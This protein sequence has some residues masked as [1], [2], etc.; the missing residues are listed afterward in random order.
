[1]IQRSHPRIPLLSSLAIGVVCAGFALGAA[2]QGSAT[3]SPPSSGTSAGSTASGK[4][5]ARTDSLAAADRRFLMNAAEGGMAEVALGQLAKERAT[6][7]AVKRFGERMVKDHT[8]ANEELTSLAQSK[9]VQLPQKLDGKHQRGIDRMSKM[10]GAEFDRAW[11]KDMVSD[12]KKDVSDFDKA[13]RDAK[14][15]DVKAFAAKT[16]P[17]LK[18]HLQVVNGLEGQVNASRGRPSTASNAPGTAK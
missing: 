13:A 14:D 8:A 15:P 17:V 6:N 4:A 5:G 3:T 9:G 7:D 10:S 11:V 1:M 2:A 16:L 12:H 18:E